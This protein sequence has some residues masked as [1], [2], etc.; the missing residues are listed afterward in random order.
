MPSKRLI[1]LVNSGY[2]VRSEYENVMWKNKKEEIL[3]IARRAS[4]ALY[5]RECRGGGCFIYNSFIAHIL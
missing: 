1:D 5:K 4:H 2:T 3:R